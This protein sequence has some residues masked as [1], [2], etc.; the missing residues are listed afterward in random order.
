[1][2]VKS[3]T[4]DPR[5]PSMLIPPNE[6]PESEAQAP[7]PQSGTL[8]MLVASDKKPPA[9]TKKTPEINPKFKDLQETGRWGTVSKAENIVVYIFVLF[10]IVGAL[11]AVWFGFIKDDDAD[12]PSLTKP[13]ESST[14][15]P[16][17]VGR[18]SELLQ[19]F[20]AM[21]SLD[22][23]FSYKQDLPFDTAY[24][25]GLMNDPAATSQ[26]RAMSWLLFQDEHDQAADA[27]K[28]W[29]LASLYFAWQGG[30]WLSAD[31]WLSSVDVCEWEHIICNIQTGNI[32]EI[33]LQSNNLVGT[34]PAEIALLNTT[35]ALWLRE[36]QLKGPLPNEVF[37]AM[38]MLSMLYLDKN[39]L[40]GTISLSIRDNQVLGKSVPTSGSNFFPMGTPALTPW[41]Q[42][43]SIYSPIVYRESGQSH[44]VVPTRPHL[45]NRLRILA[46]IAM[47]LSA[48]NRIAALRILATMIGLLQGVNDFVCRKG[49]TMVICIATR[50]TDHSTLSIVDK[51]RL[52]LPN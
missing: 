17:S 7:A 27:A 51:S 34:I 15:S 38:P 28:R 29:A 49:K 5:H 46:L 43:L 47:K 42:M 48:P 41:Q 35:Q 9:G 19:V 1:M 12:P 23:T 3:T 37:G 44:S 21:D 6:D 25:E 13:M 31:K 22:L 20:Q 24:Y 11:L 52:S 16:T 18:Q 45:F 36:N 30:N 14:G 32:R 39:Q 33:D 50:S 26:E 10:S 8:E 40:T 4:D 2:P